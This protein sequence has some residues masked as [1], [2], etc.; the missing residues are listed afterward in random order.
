MTVDRPIALLAPGSGAPEKNW[1]AASFA[2]LAKQLDQ[3]GWSS[4]LLQGP[5]DQAACQD[6]LAACEYG[7]PIVTD[8]EPSLLK[9][10]LSQVNLFVGNDSGPTHLAGLMGCATVALFGPS[11][12][13]RWRPLGER[14]ELVRAD[15]TQMHD[16]PISQVWSACQRFLQ[17]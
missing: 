10:L 8:Q 3:A 9:C 7:L 4:L 6:T 11:D 5:A 15:S 14:V 17:H 13:K 2:R 1:P 16:L 12:P